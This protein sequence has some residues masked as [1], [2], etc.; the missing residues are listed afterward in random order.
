LLAIP[1]KEM[2]RMAAARL[3][4]MVMEENVVHTTPRM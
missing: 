4:M 3:S 1:M 2:S